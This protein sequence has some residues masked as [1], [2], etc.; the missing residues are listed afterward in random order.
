MDCDREDSPTVTP[1]CE[2]DVP[3]ASLNERKPNT[4]K[5]PE[6]KRWLLCR[7]AS[8]RGKKADLVLRTVRTKYKPIMCFRNFITDHILFAGWNRTLGMVGIA[9]SL[10]L[11]I[12]HDAIDTSPEIPLQFDWKNLVEVFD[13][14]DQVPSFSN[15]QLVEYFVSRTVSDGLPAGDFKSMNTKA[16][17]LFDCGH[18]QN[19]DILPATCGLG[20]TVVL[21]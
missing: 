20:P 10:I 17:G 4:L 2:K 13:C 21:K 9:K 14:A 1:L 18:V 7:G 16:K 3:G 11:M 19:M 6:L 12:L 5:I 8:T 15:G